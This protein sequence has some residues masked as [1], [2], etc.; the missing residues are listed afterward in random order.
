MVVFYLGCDQPG[1][2]VGDNIYGHIVVME[3]IPVWLWLIGIV[4]FLVFLGYLFCRVV[5]T[6][7]FLFSQS[8]SL[9]I[10]L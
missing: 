1:V 9:I 7:C 10:Q 4:A 5:E 2:V 8:L 3:I 6:S